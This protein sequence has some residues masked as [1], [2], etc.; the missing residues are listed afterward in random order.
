MSTDKSNKYPYSVHASKK[1]SIDCKTACGS[2]CVLVAA[3][4]FGGHRISL[5]LFPNSGNMPGVDQL[6]VATPLNAKSAQNLTVGLT[7]VDVQKG[8]CG[9]DTV[10]P[11]Q[12]FLN[13]VFD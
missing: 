6:N 7:T 8:G 2:Y 10:T 1:S 13:I 11:W 4:F 5:Y 3:V 9:N 12:S